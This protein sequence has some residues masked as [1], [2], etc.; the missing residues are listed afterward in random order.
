MDTPVRV[1]RVQFSRQYPVKTFFI[2]SFL[3]TRHTRPYITSSTTKD[4][5]SRIEQNAHFHIVSYCFAISVLFP[6]G[7]T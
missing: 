7:K 6:G 2:G 5:V 1:L 3:I 4:V